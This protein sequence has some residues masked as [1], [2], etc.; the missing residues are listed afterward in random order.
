V[1]FR[2]SGSPELCPSI[3]SAVD[4]AFEKESIPTTEEL[5]RAD[6]VVD[7]RVALESETTQQM[8]GATFVVRTFTTEVM[9]RA[10][11]NR[12][13]PMAAPMSVSFDPRNRVER[14]AEHGRLVAAAIVDRILR[15]VGRRGG[16]GG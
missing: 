8:F 16:G 4:D 7:A 13:V 10:K 6:I 9:A 11:P 12:R 1:F 3:R 2:C 5:D 15:F 14:A